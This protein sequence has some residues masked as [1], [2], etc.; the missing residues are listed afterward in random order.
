M[1]LTWYSA[2]ERN[3]GIHPFSNYDDQ[4]WVLED[5]GDGYYIFKN[6]KNQNLVLDVVGGATNN[7]T[8]IEVHER[9]NGNNQKFK[10]LR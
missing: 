6:Y 3:V 5:V 4:F 10:L 2:D 8:N 9:H 7:N 1:P